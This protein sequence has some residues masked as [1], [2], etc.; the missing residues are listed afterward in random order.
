MGMLGGEASIEL[1]K[2][3]DEVYAFLEDVEKAPQ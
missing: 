3:I 1:D 2:P